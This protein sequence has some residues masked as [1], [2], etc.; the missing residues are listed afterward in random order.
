[1]K[2][3]CGLFLTR[4]Y[5]NTMASMIFSSVNF[6]NDMI[7]WSLFTCGIQSKDSTG[8]SSEI[9]A[10]IVLF[11]ARTFVSSLSS[12][13]V[14]AV[15]ALLVLAL[16]LQRRRPSAGRKLIFGIVHVFDFRLLS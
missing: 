3:I 1:M 13:P 4:L 5:H 9:V 7:G 6:T 8:R 11:I 12:A 15:E 16:A 10:P 2:C 14:A